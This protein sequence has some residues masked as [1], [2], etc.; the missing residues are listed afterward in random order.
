MQDVDARINSTLLYITTTLSF[1][2]GVIAVILSLESFIV[3]N[4]LALASKFES[5][6]S[7]KK[8]DTKSKILSVLMQLHS[9]VLYT[10]EVILLA[11]IFINDTF[12]STTAKI[13]MFIGAIISL[14]LSSVLEF[15]L[16][17]VYS[18]R[19]RLID[20]IP[21]CAQK[22]VFPFIKSF[23]KLAQGISLAIQQ[24]QATAIVLFLISFVA[25]AGYIYL[26]PSH[27]RKIYFIDLTFLSILFAE[28][29]HLVIATFD[30][31]SNN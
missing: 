15:G 28:Y 1:Q 9:K 5:P 13:I 24:P 10:L 19:V 3:L 14:I 18:V 23:F 12:E 16:C 29:L 22:S 2:I 20:E 17:Y 21:W 31:N 27:N 30:Q 8:Q 11:H 26:Q 25:V 6:E 7:A 4:L